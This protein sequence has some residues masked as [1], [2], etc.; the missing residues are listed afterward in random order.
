MN[1][2]GMRWVL[3]VTVL[4]VAALVAL[5]PPSELTPS[6]LTPSEL[7]PS[8]P[9]PTAGPRGGTDP[10]RPDLDELR[11]RAALRPCPAPAPGA[12]AAGPL[13]A[14]VLPCLGE[15]AAVDLGAA[16][17]GRPALLNFWGPLCEPCREEMPALAAY[18]AE[19]GAVAVLGVEVQRLP[20]GGLD[21]LARL[22]VHFPSVSDPDRVLQAALRSPPVLPLTYL[23]SADGRVQQVNPPEVFRSPAQVR[24]TVVRYLGEEAAG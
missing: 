19:P 5:S 20:E 24:A 15:E 1:R 4:V 6:E 22:G 23:V 17:A 16:L 13:A 14:V 18:A 10:V 11:V 9:T 8:G 21:L 3:A 2:P 7:T 12:A